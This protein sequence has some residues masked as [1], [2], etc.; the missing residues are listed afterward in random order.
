VDIRLR[1]QV[2]NGTPEPD[3]THRD[4]FLSVSPA[5]RSPHEAVAW[6]Y[7]L[8]PEQYDVMVRT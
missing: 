4:Y 7:G 2:R 8:S 5:M 1:L 6:T 3:G